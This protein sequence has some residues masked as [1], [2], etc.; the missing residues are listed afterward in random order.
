VA[1][2]PDRLRCGFED[3]PL[4]GREAGQD[5]VAHFLRLRHVHVAG[6]LAGRFRLR[7]RAPADGGGFV[8]V[9]LDGEERPEEDRPLL[10]EHLPHG[11]HRR[12]QGLLDPLRGGDG[13]VQ[14]HD[15]ADFLGARE[16]PAEGAAS[17][18][19]QLVQVHPLVGGGAHERAADA[20]Q[21]AGR[22]RVRGPLL[23][24][25]VHLPD[26]GFRRRDGL[27][28]RLIGGDAGG[29][30]TPCRTGEIAAGLDRALREGSAPEGVV[31]A[32]A[33][34]GHPLAA[35]GERFALLRQPPYC[36]ADGLL[37]VREGHL[38][39]E[40]VALLLL[41]GGDRLRGLAG[42]VQRGHAGTEGGSERGAHPR[43]GYLRG[44]EVEALL[45][46]LS[47]LAAGQLVVGVGG[48]L[49]C[50]ERARVGS[51]VGDDL[52]EALVE[53]GGLFAERVGPGF[54]RDRPLVGAPDLRLGVG[55]LLFEDVGGEVLPAIDSGH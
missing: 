7:S 24:L 3:L 29:L 9:V 22:G 47:A 48:L 8:H 42:Q 16:G 41:V 37:D 28:H 11:R 50:R 26:R 18:V 19:H 55:L 2:V 36:P 34:A 10:A 31:T 35:A 54:G 32:G 21:P 6:E 15:L 51:L 39:G 33:E 38:P 1:E 53:V 25:D 40:D 30:D 12:L 27:A 46:R 20:L 23:G 44:R 45:L 17:L 49:R 13:G 14:A 52:G 43:E 4:L 5:G